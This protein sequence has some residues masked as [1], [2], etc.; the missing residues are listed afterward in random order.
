MK[1]LLFILMVFSFRTNVNAHSANVKGYKEENSEYISSCHNKFYGYHKKDNLNHWHEVI[2]NGDKWIIVDS[3]ESFTQDPC[4]NYE[5]Q[6]VEF[7]R[8]VDGDTALFQKGG[9]EVKF[10]FLAV[11]TP[12]SVHPTKEVEDYA[13]EASG[14][15]CNMLTNASK[16]EIEYDPNSD[17]TDK[18]DR[19]LAW[20]WVNDVLLQEIMVQEGYA[21]VAYVY[22]EYKYSNNLCQV[23]NNAVKDKKGIWQYHDEIG[24][25]ETISV[26]KADTNTINTY[27]VTFSSNGNK[28]IVKVLENMQV[29]SIDPEEK[30]GYKFVGW[31]LDGKVYDFD[32][33]ITKDLVLEAK[34]VKIS[35]LYY[36]I[37]GLIVLIGYL[38]KNKKVSKK[39][40]R[41]LKKL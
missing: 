21:K 23:Q 41:L 36:I 33:E 17:I 28:K 2:Y 12:E 3:E 32:L 15:T 30:E 10:R 29:S 16:I 13:K 24:Y 26:E 34:Y 35:Y 22:G 7:I 1:I 37:A 40:K 31:Y 25:C 18:Y 27:K 8:C 4:F 39:W 11:D 6:A 14:Y 9:E 38:I 20:I 19:N 5:K